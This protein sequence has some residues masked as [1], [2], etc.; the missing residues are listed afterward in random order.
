MNHTSRRTCTILAVALAGGVATAQTTERVNVATDG[1]Q[2]NAWSNSFSEAISADGRFVAFQSGATNLVPGDTNL[3]YDAFVHDRRS[4]TTERISVSTGGAGGD[5]SSGSPAISADG[6]YVA[7]V[8]SATNLVPG[9]TNAR[10]DVF[11][12]DRQLGTTER[13]SVSTAGV[14]GNHHS[15]ACS[16]SADGRFVAFHSGAFNL[17]AGDT[18]G[19]WDVFVHD[20][21]SSVTERVSLSSTGAQGN[22]RSDFPALSADGR[23]VAFQSVASNLVPGD[24]NGGTDVFVRDRQSG[25]TERVNLST[26]GAQADSSSGAPR[27][28]ADG[29]FVAFTSYATNLVAGDT[30]GW[31]DTFVRDRSNGTTERV[32]VSTSG[33]QANSYCSGTSIS[34]AG[35]FVAFQTGASNLIPGDSSS[36]DV[37]LRDRLSGTTERVSLAT[38]SLPAE[39]DSSAGSLSPDGRFVVFTSYAAN[40]AVSD[41]N[42]AP[43]VFVRDRGGPPPSFPFCFGI[44][45]LAVCPCTPSASGNGCPNSVNLGGANLV[46]SGTASILSDTLVLSGTGMPDGSALY[47]QGTNRVDGGSGASFGDGLRCA[48]GVITRLGTKTNVAGVSRYPEPGDP[49]ISQVGG[50]TTTSSRTYQVWYRDPTPYCTPAAFNLTNGFE[51]AWTL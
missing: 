6:R 12:R 30:N 23:F 22:F 5:L 21:R 1:T 11:L 28:S 26:A 48:G 2:T 39:G 38:T 20:R 7:F 50:L 4:G 27:I 51:V 8:S 3:L 33:T 10:S 24:A 13:V 42:Q 46:A 41:T 35:R 34:A 31:W 40:L 14:Q 17:V 37:F 49:S 25:T 19:I 18:N 36:I 15:E 47:F 44:S 32:S 16:I 45:M 9:D 29:R 43:D